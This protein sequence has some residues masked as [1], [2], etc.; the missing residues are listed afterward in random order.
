MIVLHAH[1]IRCYGYISNT[2]R[3]SRLRS[4]FVISRL[5]PAFPQRKQTEVDYVLRV[6]SRSYSH[7]FISS[8]YDEKYMWNSC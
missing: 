1:T 7:A 4:V 2:P 6:P 5:T 3:H 8:D